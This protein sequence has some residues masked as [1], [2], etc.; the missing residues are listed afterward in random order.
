MAQR[1]SAFVADKHMSRILFIAHRIPFPPN[2]GDKIRS[3]NILRHLSQSHQVDLAFLIDDRQD[4]DV[5]SRLHA[6]AERICFAAIRPKLRKIRSLLAL[7]GRRPLSVPYFYTAYLQNK[8][9]S[10]LADTHY[11]CVFCFSSPTAEY[12]FASHHREKMFRDSLLLMDLVDVDSMKWRDYAGTASFPMNMIYDQESKRLLRFEQKIIKL[13]DKVLLV[14]EA[15]KQI[16]EKYIPHRGNVMAI[17]NGVDLEQFSPAG[18][19]PVQQNASPCLVFTGAMDYRPNIDGVLWFAREILPHVQ[20]AIPTIG[21]MIVG[22]NPAPEIKALA[23]T[24]ENITVTGFV[25]DI[26]GY[27]LG[28]DICVV[29]LLI[30]RGIQNKVLE[31]M[32]LGRPVIATPQ[33]MEGIAARPGRDVLVAGDPAAFASAVIDLLGDTARRQN[34][35]RNARLCMEKKYSWRQNLRQLNTIIESGKI[36]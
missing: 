32:A 17:S 7:A 26:R 6:Y 1:S 15:E 23:A 14:S 29:P 35:G 2:K 18:I 21:F 27:I 28:A 25:D 12:V 34:L 3:F 9:D 5:V 22:S 19:T 30:A 31:A 13:F 8:I 36:S 11:D 24:T 16:L 20:K 33:A 4:L 10:W